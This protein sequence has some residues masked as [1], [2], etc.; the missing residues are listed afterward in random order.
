MPLRGLVDSLPY[1]V[2]TRDAAGQV[3]W[4]NSAYLA[5]VEAADLATLKARSLELLDQ[6]ERE[7]AASL[8]QSGQAAAFRARRS[9]LVSAVSSKCSSSPL[10]AA[11][12]AMP[13]M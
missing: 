3:S 2:W 9:W 8:R 11:A 7:R 6:S 1:P 4:A 10:Q 13:S 5:A 12:P